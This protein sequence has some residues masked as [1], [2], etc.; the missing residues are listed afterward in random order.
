MSMR[1]NELK[2]I[3]Q[4][5]PIILKISANNNIAKYNYLKRPKCSQIKKSFNYE[6]FKKYK[7]LWYSIFRKEIVTLSLIKLLFV[8]LNVCIYM[9]ICMNMTMYVCTLKM[10]CVYVC[11]VCIYSQDLKMC[12]CVCNRD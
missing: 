12:I 6:Y 5:C 10:K 9:C 7:F 8:T 11:N 1:I 4:I 3:D 2:I